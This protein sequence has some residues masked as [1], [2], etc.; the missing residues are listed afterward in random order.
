[1]AKQWKQS[2]NREKNQSQI[3]QQHERLFKLYEKIDFYFTIN[4]AAVHEVEPHLMLNK[5]MLEISNF[6]FSIDNEMTFLKSF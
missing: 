1:M 3:S 4:S 6:L 5:L 2:I